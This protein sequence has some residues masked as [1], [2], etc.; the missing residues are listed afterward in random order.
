M[1]VNA[2]STP[3]HLTVAEIEA[4]VTF[5]RVKNVHLSVHPPVGAVTVTAPEQMNIEVVRAFVINKLSWIRSERERFI[6]QP[7]ASQALYINAE[8]HYVWGSRLLLEVI[9]RDEPPHVTQEMNRLVL[10]VRPNSST[11]KRRDTLESW[12][13]DQ[14]RATAQPIISAWEARLNV[15]V[16]QLYI[17]R[18]KT[19]WGSCNHEKAHI[20]LNSELAKKPVPCLEYIIVHEMMHLL[21]PTHSARFVSLMDT[22]LPMWRER[23]AELNA[24]LLSHEEWT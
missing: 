23:K 21:E 11:K 8:S 3:V 6:N 1:I 7:R 24:T 2:S 13:R 15:T 12:Y 19:K 14:L 4:L 20:R 16:S 17:Q 18:M 10:Q 9:E 5:K 22:H